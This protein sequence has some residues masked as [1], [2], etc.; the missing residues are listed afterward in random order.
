MNHAILN[1]A[2]KSNGS[3][4]IH[5]TL[6]DGSEMCAFGPIV[7][8]SE[9]AVWVRDDRFQQPLHGEQPN[10]PVAF[11][12]GHACGVYLRSIARINVLKGDKLSDY[13]A[14]LPLTGPGE[15]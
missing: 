5:F 3:V 13:P 2:K 11:P 4:Q 6:P 12:P 7:R 10:T 9:Y 14:Q 8:L 1:E 15:V